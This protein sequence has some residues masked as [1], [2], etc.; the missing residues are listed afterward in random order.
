MESVTHESVDEDGGHLTVEGEEQG[1][2]L[3]AA[4]TQR[5]TQVGDLDRLDFDVSLSFIGETVSQLSLQWLEAIRLQKWRQHIL[6]AKEI[7]N[8]ISTN[9]Y[10]PDED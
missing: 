4:Q 8:A 7:I 3:L 9:E 1:E 2:V 6:A 5:H 10:M